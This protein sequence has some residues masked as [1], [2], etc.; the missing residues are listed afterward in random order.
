MSP[1]HAYLILFVGV[2]LENAGIPLPGETALLATA[3]LSSA[4]GGAHLSLGW[5]ILAAF[6]G[7]VIGDNLGYW[8]GRELARPRLANG[9][10]FLFL[11]P[12]RLR[13]AEGYFAQYGVLTVFFGRFVAL[14]RIAAGPAAGVSGMAW[15]RFALANA[16]G[17]AVWSSVIG[18]L[19]YAAGPAWE[20]LHRWLGWSA[21]ALV[22]L[23]VLGVVGWHVVPYFRR[24]GEATPADVRNGT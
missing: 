17:A 3:F 18:S 13:K 6:G 8:A 2:M 23:L 4:A 16:A 11:T 9:K 20:Q 14:L 5:V 21:W 1:W 22:G 19:G 10:R 7:A 15:W 12:E 24:K